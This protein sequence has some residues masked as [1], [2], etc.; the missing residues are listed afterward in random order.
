MLHIHGKN[1]FALFS[2]RLRTNIAITQRSIHS[3]LHRKQLSRV[4]QPSYAS[5]RTKSH[6]KPLVPSIWPKDILFFG[7]TPPISPIR[8]SYLNQSQKM[9]VS[10]FSCLRWARYEHVCGLRQVGATRSEDSTSISYVINPCRGVDYVSRDCVSDGNL[11]GAAGGHE[12]VQDWDS[13]F[14]TSP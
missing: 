13:R 1:S 10:H 5:V 11:C 4:L 8:G 3:G 2:F 12:H 14:C 7:T 9:G 6:K